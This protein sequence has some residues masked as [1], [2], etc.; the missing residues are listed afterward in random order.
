LEPFTHFLTGACLGRAGLN[1]KTALATATLAFAAEFPDIDVLWSWTSAH[2]AYA[3]HRGFTHTLFWSP[4]VA[5]GSW[6]VVYV[7]HHWWSKRQTAKIDPEVVAREAAETA[8]LPVELR[9][10][11]PQP[12]N[13]KLLY[14]YALLATLSASTSACGPASV[15]LGSASALERPS[16]ARSARP[17]FSE[18][19]WNAGSAISTVP[20]SMA[21]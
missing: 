12:V 21:Q 20:V 6:S 10:L 4:L 19:K 13:W 17:L 9:P 1:R 7:I 5:L 15:E 11:P 14:V 18:E 2:A 16:D 3:H 8:E